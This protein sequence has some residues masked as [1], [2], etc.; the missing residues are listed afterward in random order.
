MADA[1][2]TV[3]DL[4][5]LAAYLVAIPLALL[6]GRPILALLGLVILGTGEAISFAVFRQVRDG[7]MDEW[8]WSL[9]ALHGVAVA[10]L[11]VWAAARPARPGSRWEL[12]AKGGASGQTH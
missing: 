9:F 2:L 10:A 4:A 12:R 7:G 1:V 6:K 3:V 8:V 5:V 11:L